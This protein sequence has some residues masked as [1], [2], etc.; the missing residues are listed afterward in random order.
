MNKKALIPLF[1]TLGFAA[2][3]ASAQEIALN[4]N[5]DDINTGGYYSY[6]NN[7]YAGVNWSNF[8][9]INS[10]YLPGT[11]YQTGVVSQPNGAFDGSGSSAS[12]DSTPGNTFYL[13]NAYFTAAW[14]NETVTAVGNF[15]LYSTTFAVNTAGP[16]N[17]AFNWANLTDVT[18][19][20]N[21]GSQF[22]VDNIATPIPAAL[23]LVGSGLAGVFGFAR[24]KAGKG[25]QA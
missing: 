2:G 7:G 8:Y 17:V 3:S 21:G 4:T 23:W 19:T 11:G 24:R 12:I 15:G 1:L 6:I 20:P 18:F 16:V 25:I 13:G 14:W 5:F 9:A 10:G 22:V